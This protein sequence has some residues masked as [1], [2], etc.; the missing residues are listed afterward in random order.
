MVNLL[1]ATVNFEPY[2]K[3][4]SVENSTYLDMCSSVDLVYS[5]AYMGVVGLDIAHMGCPRPFLLL[6][7]TDA[8]YMLHLSADLD[9]CCLTTG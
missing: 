9:T 3:H 8:L 5:P 7:N 1:L 4:Q 6:H 2:S